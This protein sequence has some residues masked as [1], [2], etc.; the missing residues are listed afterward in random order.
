MDDPILSAVLTPSGVL[1]KVTY[2]LGYVQR[3]TAKMAKDTD[4]LL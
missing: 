1:E 4:T 3:I 2:E